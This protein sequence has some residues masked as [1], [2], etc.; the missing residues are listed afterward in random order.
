[1]TLALSAYGIAQGYTLD[2]M[3]NM[4]NT[5]FSSGYRS[6]YM[7]PL[8]SGTGYLLPSY[9]QGFLGG[10]LYKLN[11]NAAGQNPV[12]TASQPA[13]TVTSLLRSGSAIFASLSNSGKGG[14]V[15]LTESGTLPNGQFDIALY[16]TLTNAAYYP[17]Q[18]ARNGTLLYQ[19]LGEGNSA[20]SGA[21]GTRIR[22]MVIDPTITDPTMNWATW[23]EPYANPIQIASIP[24][25][26]DARNAKAVSIAFSS[27]GSSLYFVVSSNGG[28][29][30]P[31]RILGYTVSTKVKTLDVLINDD[32]SGIATGTGLLAGKLLIC[33]AGGI[34]EY[35]I[36][37]GTTNNVATGGTNQAYSPSFSA[38]G[39]N[40][41]FFYNQGNSGSPFNTFGMYRITAPAPLF[42]SGTG[43]P[44]IPNTPIGLLWNTPNLPDGNP[45]CQGNKLSLSW[46]PSIGST[47][48]KLRRG[49][50]VV[51]DGMSL[52]FD[53]Y[54][55]VAG[56]SYSYTISA[57]NTTGES[58]Q[59]AAIVL[60]PCPLQA[61][62]QRCL[63][64]VGGWAERCLT[65][66]Q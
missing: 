38:F 46:M 65:R 52:S 2:L 53:D 8:L 36:A 3:A 21:S 63:A 55:V 48:Y 22:V 62:A 49:G 23:I 4:G 24:G 11:T 40:Q 30:T 66:S 6:G 41:A 43:A 10:H 33:R 45:K 47:G 60:T 19:A 9:K 1:M 54:G 18:L 25:F 56:T 64:R 50:V 31:S 5:I 17:Q 61:F 39:T 59:S 29:G 20:Q 15:T 26:S 57:Y 7:L 32:I 44:P 16:P 37:D 42:T 13:Q 27:D 51:Y 14:V 35:T 34:D 28:T 58:S 12:D